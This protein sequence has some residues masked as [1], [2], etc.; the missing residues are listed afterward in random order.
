MQQ[1]RAFR[2]KRCG[3]FNFG[4]QQSGSKPPD[5]TRASPQASGV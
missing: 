5:A 1:E 3:I 4:I 2:Q